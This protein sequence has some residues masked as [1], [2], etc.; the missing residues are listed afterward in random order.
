V[1]VDAHQPQMW[2]RMLQAI[3]GFEAGTLGLGKLV[4]DLRGLYVEADPHDADVRF[5]FETFWS[6]IDGENELR[7]E[8]WAPSGSST[9][10]SLRNALD[11]FRGFVQGLFAAPAGSDHG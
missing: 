8:P 10:Q 1:V 6:A 2:Q 9:D 3:E 7:S 5:G 11:A 4:D